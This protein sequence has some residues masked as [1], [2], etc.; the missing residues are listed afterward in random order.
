MA[1]HPTVQRASQAPRGLRVTVRADKSLEIRWQTEDGA[2]LY[3]L[4]ICYFPFDGPMIQP[5]HSNVLQVEGAAQHVPHPE[6]LDK[7]QAWVVKIGLKARSADGL[8]SDA[9]EAQVA[10]E[11]QLPGEE[12]KKAL[13]AWTR[14]FQGKYF[15]PFCDMRGENPKILVLGP[16]HHGKSS[17][18]NHMNRCLLANLG[19]HDERD[20]AP[21]GVE[22]KTVATEALQIPMGS[23]PVTFIDTPAFATMNS[24]STR[25]L[26]T[27]LSSGNFCGQRRSDLG[28]DE[29]SL[30]KKPPHAAIVVIS[31]C[32]WR[33]QMEEMK[34]YLMKIANEFKNASQSMV[35]FP[36]VI[37]A[38]NCDEFLKDC[39][40]E[41]PKDELEK[42][43][44]GI[45]KFALT[46]HVY[47]ITNYKRGS[48]ASAR[49]N[50]ATFDLLS[51]LL[52]KAKHRD[53]GVK[54]TR[55]W[56]VA[57]VACA[58][59]PVVLMVICRLLGRL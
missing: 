18:V 50:E 25:K 12:A 37:A 30:F 16:Q 43:V 26:Q 57:H 53:T 10:M 11:D 8:L 42:A 54:Q 35:E 45:K 41:N 28:H 44:L 52:T 2:C 48:M 55:N 7:G 49:N 6:S 24:E 1:V 40:T 27:L 31:L 56:Y 29:S 33:D 39:Q 4:Q 34:M 36:Y 47:A 59:T 51:Q 14:N 9:A 46:D 58:I 13:E 5:S 20:Q 3:E 38:T 15:A 32:H 21:A 19:L 17:F 22:E 23:S